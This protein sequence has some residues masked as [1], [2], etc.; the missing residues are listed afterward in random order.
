MPVLGAVTYEPIKAVRLLGGLGFPAMSRHAES[1]SQT[2][3]LGVPLVL[4]DGYVEEWD[5]VS[6][7]DIFG[8]SSE[9]GHNLTT[10]GTAKQLSEGTPPNQA[11]AV[12]I[13]VGAW[14]RDGLCGYYA[15]DGRTV[16]SIAVKTGEVFTAA[17]VSE[18]TLYGLTKDATTGFWYLDPTDTAGNNAIAKVLGL[19]PTTPNPNSATNGSRVLFQFSLANRYFE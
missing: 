6:D 3:K 16:F 13:P 17:M 4:S 19:D 9:P 7:V 10:D 18:T 14:V 8:V 12:T 2:F 11:S 15:A 5:G 1:A